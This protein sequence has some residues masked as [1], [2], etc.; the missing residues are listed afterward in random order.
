[1]LE[2]LLL[3]FCAGALLS[4]I[5]A[6]LGA[7]VV[8]RKMAYFGDTISHASIL[9]IALGICLQVNF[10]LAII[11]LSIILALTMIGLEKR[12]NFTADTILGI[13]SHT[14]L[15]LGVVAVALLRNVRVDLMNYLFGDLLAITTSDLGII[16]IGVA[17]ILAILLG[18][19]RSLL[20]ITIA[21][22]LALVEGVKVQRLKALLMILIT[23][24]IA[25]SMQFVGAL[26][27]TSLLIIPS[28]TA[29]RFA[30]SPEQMAVLA[31][32]IS[33][34]ALALGLIA[35]A[36]LDTPS[37]PSVVVSAS[38]LFLLSLGKAQ[39]D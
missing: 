21:P 27:I 4:L 16:A 22:E 39:R 38:L 32:I 23:L 19:W 12:S 36:Y 2:I 31:V 6:P 35:S 8:W 37:A 30:R 14:T 3:P 18:F 7:F 20:A 11:V 26:I 1:M 34:I 9:G 25:L 17:V 33:I 28:A 15:S 24:T 29:R 13:I 5:T 10:Y